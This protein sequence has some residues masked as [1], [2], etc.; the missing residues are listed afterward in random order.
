MRS[1]RSGKKRGEA[2]K[3]MVMGMA[4]C[5][6]FLPIWFREMEADEFNPITPMGFYA[7]QL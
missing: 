1:R 5:S 6:T 7:V 3:K 2:R 4:W